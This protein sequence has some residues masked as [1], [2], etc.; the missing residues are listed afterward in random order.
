[1]AREPAYLEQLIPYSD[2]KEFNITTKRQLSIASRKS[3]SAYWKSKIVIKL[4]VHIW[5]QGAIKIQK[6]FTRR[7]TLEE[8]AKLNN[9]RV[10]YV[11]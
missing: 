9:Q 1:M 2:I 6:G 8:H 5:Q 10:I 3:R 11:Q 4:S 7:Q